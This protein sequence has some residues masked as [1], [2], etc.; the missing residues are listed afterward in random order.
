VSRWIRKQVPTILGLLILIVAW[1][2]FVII[3]HIKSYLLPSPIE[4][5]RALTDMRWRWHEQVLVTTIEVIGGF[6]LSAVIGIFLGMAIAWSD[7]SRRVI[8]PFIV[9]LNSLPKIAMAPLFIIWL[10]YGIIPNIWIAFLCAFFPITINSATG[11]TEI[12]PDMV[13]L[14]RS[15]RVPKWK[16]FLKIRIPNALPYIFTGLKISATMAVV[17]AVVG[18]FIASTRGLAS[19]IMSA[20]ASLSTHAIFA[21]LIWISALGLVLFGVISGLERLFMPWAYLQ[22]G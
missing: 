21:A 2:V 1:Q 19:V 10:G 3:T 20:Q 14:A 11:V 6:A 9:F 17:G 15:L 4:V 5:L 18:E 16:I 13:D 12:E 8:M 22:K 7:L